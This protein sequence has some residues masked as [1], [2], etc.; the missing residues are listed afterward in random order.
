MS[1]RS[2]STPPPPTPQKKRKKTF[3]PLNLRIEKKPSA[4]SMKWGAEYLVLKCGSVITIT[5]RSEKGFKQTQKVKV[6]E[7][8]VDSSKKVLFP[9]QIS[10]EENPSVQSLTLL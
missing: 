9:T 10:D 8:S 2:Q 1:A 7:H 4:G 5:L 3:S 6:N